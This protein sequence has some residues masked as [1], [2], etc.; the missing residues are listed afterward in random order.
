[1]AWRVPPR[2]Y[3]KFTSATSLFK[4]HRWNILLPPLCRPGHLQSLLRSLL[5]VELLKSTEM[6]FL[7]PAGLKTAYNFCLRPRNWNGSSGV[8][9]CY[10][11]RVV[12]Y[13]AEQDPHVPWC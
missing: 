11:P 6:P 1:M 12:H 8:T 3:A 2:L 13:Q 7:D 9:C 4:I 5:S 10:F